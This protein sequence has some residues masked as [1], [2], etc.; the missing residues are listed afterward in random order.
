MNWSDKKTTFLSS[1]Y[2]GLTHLNAEK[3]EL[4][5]QEDDLPVSISDTSVMSSIF[6]KQNKSFS[7]CEIYFHILIF[8][9]EIRKH[10]ELCGIETCARNYMEISMKED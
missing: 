1:I 6:P 5:G 10:Q 8:S 7:F 3:D 9:E 4:D 2:N